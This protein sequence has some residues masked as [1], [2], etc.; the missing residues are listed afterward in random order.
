M[1]RIERRFSFGDNHRSQQQRSCQ[2]ISRASRALHGC[3]SPSDNGV[4]ERKCL[5]GCPSRWN[6]SMQLELKELKSSMEN[7]KDRL[8]G[9]EHNFYEKYMFTWNHPPRYEGVWLVRNYPCDF[10]TP[11]RDLYHQSAQTRVLVMKP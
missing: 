10:A 4:E 2:A 3:W 5:F 11:R 1:G 6:P 8:I 9:V 7:F